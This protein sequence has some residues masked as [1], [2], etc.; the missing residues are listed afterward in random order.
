MA[1]SQAGGETSKWLVKTLISLLPT[2]R[3]QLKKQVLVDVGAISG[4]AYAKWPM[5]KAFSIDLNPRAD[6]VL[7][8]DW[9]ELVPQDLKLEPNTL[10]IVALS[11]VLNFQGELEKRADMILHSHLF[12]KPEGKVCGFCSCDLLP[13]P[14]LNTI[15]TTMDCCSSCLRQLYI[16]LPLACLNNSRYL[17][18][19][20]FKSM[21]RSFG[22]GAVLKQHDSAK[23]SYWLL[24]RDGAEAGWDGQTFKKAEI[25]AGV[26]R[27]NFAIVKK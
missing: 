12:L 18:H 19:K 23:L 11:L 6:S 5:M 10:D 17:T 3:H 7:K 13:R 15:T 20:H 1:G 16:V 9:L 27:N 8:W 24:Q 21:L 2:N 22:F 4:T 14:Q 26:K 25:R